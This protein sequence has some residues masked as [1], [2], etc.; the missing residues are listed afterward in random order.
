MAE[1]RAGT[2]NISIMNLEP[3]RNARKEG[4]IQKPLHNDGGEV[5][6]HRSQQNKQHG[7]GL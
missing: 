4:S 2:E 3:S 1:S 5:K 7:T 6:E